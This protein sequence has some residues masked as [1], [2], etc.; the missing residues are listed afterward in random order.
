MRSLYGGIVKSSRRLAREGFQSTSSERCMAEQLFFVVV[1]LG[2]LL[3]AQEGLYR[4]ARSIKR[5]LSRYRAVP[6]SPSRLLALVDYY[7]VLG[8][9]AAIVRDNGVDVGWGRYVTIFVTALVAVEYRALR[10]VLEAREEGIYTNDSRRIVRDAARC[11]ALAP[12]MA[13]FMFVPA[14]TYAPPI[15]W[16]VGAGTWLFHT[17]GLNVALF[18]AGAFFGGRSVVGSFVLVLA[19]LSKPEV[20]CEICGSKVFGVSTDD[21]EFRGRN[22]C[23]YCVRHRAS[24]LER[25]KGD[26]TPQVE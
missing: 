23:S 2:V 1:E 18:L 20:L 15:A 9:A 6:R 26:P 3:L 10:S 7:V 12:A 19:L 16:T 22:I 24:D 8:T 14:L 5:A 25:L 11:V 4:A 13:V 17:L 21:P